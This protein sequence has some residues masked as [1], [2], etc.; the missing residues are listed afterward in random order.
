MSRVESSQLN[1]ARCSVASSV[2]N[3]HGFCDE[4]RLIDLDDRSAD[5][6]HRRREAP[7]RMKSKLSAGRAQ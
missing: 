1:Q 7:A 2:E 3:W 4:L 6:H 5:T